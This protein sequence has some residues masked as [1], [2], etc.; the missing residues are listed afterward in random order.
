MCGLI[1][2]SVL[3][4]ARLM[5]QLHLTQFIAVANINSTLFKHPSAL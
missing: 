2:F 3:V 5:M 1:L 4:Q